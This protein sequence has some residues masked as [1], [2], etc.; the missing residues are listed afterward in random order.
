VR[1][2]ITKIKKEDVYNA[3]TTVRVVDY[4]VE[5]LTQIFYASVVQIIII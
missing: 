4:Q 5:A 2:D 3:K 1:K